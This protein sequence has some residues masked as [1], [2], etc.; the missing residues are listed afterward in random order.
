MLCIVHQLT[1][2]LTETL[3]PSGTSLDLLSFLCQHVFN[4]S[5]WF[6]LI[7]ALCCFFILFEI[8]MIR[9]QGHLSS[10]RCVKPS[11]QKTNESRCRDTAAAEKSELLLSWYKPLETSDK[12]EKSGGIWRE[13]KATFDKE[14][15]KEWSKHKLRQQ[16]TLSPRCHCGLG[17]VVA[18]LSSRRTLTSR[19]KR[20]LCVLIGVLQLYSLL[21]ST[22]RCV[23]STFIS[24]H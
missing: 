18:V 13:V 24:C 2:L 6:M 15:Q 12:A 23:Y 16:G 11:S 19:W 14:R 4:H 22:S 5:Y 9:K 20:E 10:I 3:R 7:A 8:K 21:L 17:H 1:M